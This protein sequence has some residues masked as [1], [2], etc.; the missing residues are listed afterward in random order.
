MRLR[1]FAQEVIAQGLVLS[2]AKLLR[3]VRQADLLSF[4][5]GCRIAVIADQDDL[6]AAA[7]TAC[8][9]LG[10][11]APLVPCQSVWRSAAAERP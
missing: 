8:T 10:V 2:Q 9:T 7:S 3:L 11:Y 4:S 1:A 5:P 6:D